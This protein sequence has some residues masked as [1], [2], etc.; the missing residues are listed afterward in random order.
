M[1]LGTGMVDVLRF[2]EGIAQGGWRGV[3]TDALRVLSIL[4]PLGKAGGMLSR[5][6]HLQMIRLAAKPVGMTGPC[7]FQA[8]NNAMTIAKGRPQNLFLT[9]REAASAL[10]LRLKDIPV[11]K[12]KY[13]LASWIDDLVPFLRKQ[14]AKIKVL[15]QPKT[16][17][18]VVNAARSQNG[19]TI[20]AIKALRPGKD[21]FLHSIIAVRNEFG[22]VR[23]ADYGG[24]FYNSVEELIRAKKGWGDVQLSTLELFVKSNPAT[25]VEGLALTGL[26]E[27]AMTVF[28]GSIVVI[29]GVTAI[30]MLEGVDLAVPVVMAAVPEPA[31]QDAAPPAVVKASFEAYVARREGRP[32]I[33]MPEMRLTAHKPPRADWLTGVQ[34]RLNAAGFGAGPVDGVNGPMTKAAVR[35]FQAACPPLRS[36]GIP[37]PRT[38]ARLVQ[39]CGY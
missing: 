11:E 9:A 16:I 8:V 34:Y 26:L 29:E 7:T 20:F 17:A 21:P 23:F 31:K 5:F 13:E 28:R 24:K 12:G 15:P 30:E 19:V 36:D 38:Q 33:K 37:G 35:A 39:I 22:Q 27:D 3:G 14:G 25:V 32:V 4:G 18:D 6:G 2:G 1:E 10:G